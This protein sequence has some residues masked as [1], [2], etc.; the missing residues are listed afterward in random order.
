MKCQRC[1][2]ELEEN[3]RFCQN[4]GY[5]NGMA[6]GQSIVPPQSM[7]MEHQKKKRKKDGGKMRHMDLEEL[8]LDGYL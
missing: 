5:D 7:G 4:C 6:G 1:G 8:L 3:A 2:S